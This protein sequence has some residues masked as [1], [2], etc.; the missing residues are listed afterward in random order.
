[1]RPSHRLPVRRVTQCVCIFLPLRSAAAVCIFLPVCNCFSILPLRAAYLE[2]PVLEH[3]LDC[4]NIA[5]VVEMDLGWSDEV[6][7]GAREDEQPE[8]K[9]PPR[10]GEGNRPL[11]RKCPTLVTWKTMPN[12]PLPMTRVSL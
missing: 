11:A 10:R 5:R 2:A 9:K 8:Q 6:T 1:M 4:N 3:L 12:E 7:G